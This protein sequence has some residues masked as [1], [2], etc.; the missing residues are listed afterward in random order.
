MRTDTEY[1]RKSPTDSVAKEN[2][3]LVSLP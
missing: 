3:A 2:S 1:R